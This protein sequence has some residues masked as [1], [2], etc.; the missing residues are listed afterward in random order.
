MY[1]YVKIVELEN[2]EKQ[3]NFAIYK[4]KP[5]KTPTGYKKITEAEYNELIEQLNKENENKEENEN[6]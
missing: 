6:V 1:Y 5:K 2:G 4:K 3:Y